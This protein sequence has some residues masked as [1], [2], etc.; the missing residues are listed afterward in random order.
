M[1]TFWRATVVVEPM[2][3]L[4]WGAR[5]EARLAIEVARAKTDQRITCLWRCEGAKARDGIQRIDEVTD[6]GGVDEEA[7]ALME[8]LRERW[9][10][11]RDRKET[12]ECV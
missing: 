5:R 2:P 8:R 11:V 7:A 3:V 10:V 9:C 1:A 12:R 4:A 6:G